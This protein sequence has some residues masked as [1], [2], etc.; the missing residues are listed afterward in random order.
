MIEKEKLMKHQ[1]SAVYDNV[2]IRPL[3][4]SDIENLRK[5]R[6]SEDKTQY[7]RKIS[8]ITPQMQEEWYERYLKN[9]D[10]VTFAIDETKDLNRMVGSVS[11]YNFNGNTAEIGKIQIGDEE[12]NG[13]GIGRKSLVM[14]M[15]I[16]F[17]MM[18]ID[19]IVGSVH[20]E[21]IAAHKNDIRIGFQIVGKHEA[22]MG[23]IEDEIEIDEKKLME[24]NTYVD[25]IIIENK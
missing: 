10:E 8:Y 13:R 18:N 17:K 12:A 22:P 16:A 2:R 5:W 14:A 7:L 23:G 19:K 9:T 24:V 11:L 25:K 21:N 15:S 3:E 4:K 20:Q 1:Y 6:N